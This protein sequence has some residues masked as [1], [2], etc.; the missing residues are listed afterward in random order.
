[1]RWR[2]RERLGCVA[3]GRG[4][5]RLGCVAG[6]RGR[7]RLGC[8]AGGR[9]RERWGC[10]AGGRGRHTRPFSVS[11]VS[12]TTR[13]AFSCQIIL[14]MSLIVSFFGPNRHRLVKLYYDL[15]SSAYLER[16]IGGGGGG[17]QVFFPTRCRHNTAPR[18]EYLVS[19]SNIVSFTFFHY[20]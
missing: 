9:G 2:G 19:V 7:E 3:G 11:S 10:V 13:S 14:H 18:G 8:V 4:R 20:C 5:E 16:I 12:I 17:P 6:G 15:D 1:M